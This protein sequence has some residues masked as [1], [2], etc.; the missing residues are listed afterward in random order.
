MTRDACGPVAEEIG[1][2]WHAGGRGRGVEHCHGC[3]DQGV[4]AKTGLVGRTV[5]RNQHVVDDLLVARVA[6]AKGPRDLAVDITDRHHHVGATEPAAA[7]AQIDCLAAAGRG[8]G[9]RNRP[10]EGAAGECHFSLD[11]GSAA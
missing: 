8:A 6:S 7:V 9:R 1:I 4:G 11:G 5:E 10:P 2:E 3:P